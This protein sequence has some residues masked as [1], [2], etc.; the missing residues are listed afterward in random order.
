MAI[1]TESYKK[2]SNFE[3]VKQIKIMDE[4]VCTFPPDGKWKP[5]SIFRSID[6]YNISQKE[7][8]T[9]IIVIKRVNDGEE[10]NGEPK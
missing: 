7:N 9:L 3:E 10:F 6:E 8:T 5:V 4:M 1:E 2:Y